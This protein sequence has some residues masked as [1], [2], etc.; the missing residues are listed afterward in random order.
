[1]EDPD[2]VQ[3]ASIVEVKTE[4]LVFVPGGEAGG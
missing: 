2:P 3:T 1:M 4:S